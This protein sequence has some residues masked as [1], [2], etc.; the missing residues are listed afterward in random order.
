MNGVEIMRELPRSFEILCEQT[1]AKRS[2]LTR[3]IRPVREWRS[4]PSLM[5]FQATTIECVELFCNSLLSHWL[6]IT[7]SKICRARLAS[8]TRDIVARQCPFLEL[9]NSKQLHHIVKDADR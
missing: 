8:K 9:V 3:S 4:M 7:R 5:A 1:H 6:P 2:V